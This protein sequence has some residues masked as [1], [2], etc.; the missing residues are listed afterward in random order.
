[1]R[2]SR[3]LA[4]LGRHRGDLGGNLALCGLLRGVAGTDQEEEMDIEKLGSALGLSVATLEEVG[5]V[6]IKFEADSTVSVTYGR[7]ITDFDSLCTPASE[8]GDS[9]H[10]GQIG[11]KSSAP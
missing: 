8:Y 10:H 2:E 1:M 3:L 4:A 11:S 7:P 6:T 5:S 9:E